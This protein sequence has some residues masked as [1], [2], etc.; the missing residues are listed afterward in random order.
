MSEVVV[1]DIETTGFHRN[2]DRV[3][4][5]AAVTV[6]LEA[7]T[8]TDLYNNV[9]R[10][11]GRWGGRRQIAATWICK[12]GIIQVDEVLEALPVDIVA[13]EFKHVLGER[14]GR[15]TAYNLE[16]EE[17]FLLGETWDLWPSKL[18]C[19]MLAATPVCKLPNRYG[20][21]D[22]KWPGL[23]EAYSIII[24][25]ELDKHH[26]ALEDARHAAEVMLK[27]IE[28]GAYQVEGGA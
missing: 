16:F 6:D 25:R 15:W 14:N 10:P 18:P 3:L 21:S 19:L 17:R 2:L 11:D 4:E 13:A 7:G 27:L 12:N 1:V 26:R 8:I 5:V 24:G 9:C 23:E 28:M 20:Y 22:Y